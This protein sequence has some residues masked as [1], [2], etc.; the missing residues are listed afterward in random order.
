MVCYRL[1]GSL[2]KT[3][4]IM[5]MHHI[6]R[7]LW[8]SIYQKGNVAKLASQQTH[9]SLK[10]QKQSNYYI[11][12]GLNTDSVSVWLNCRIV[13]MVVIAHS[14]TNSFFNVLRQRFTFFDTADNIKFLANLSFEWFW[15]RLQCN[16]FL[17]L[18]KTNFRKKDQN[19]DVKQ[20]HTVEQ[21]IFA[22]RKFSWYTVLWSK[23]TNFSCHEN[24]LF[25]SML[26]TFRVN[27]HILHGWILSRTDLVFM[28]VCTC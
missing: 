23:F 8:A 11:T 28:Y 26:V 5:A 20:L 24:V 3:H 19:H 12:Y 7:K 25:Y 14:I 1:S 17:D 4:H 15:L 16:E 21:E 22:C 6:M 2:P 9:F 18:E 13:V 27:K 10:F